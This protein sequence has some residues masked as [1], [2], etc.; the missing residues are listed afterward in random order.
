MEVLAIIPARSGSKSVKNKNIRSFNGKPLLA[1]SIQ[2]ALDSERVTRVIVS[3]DSEEYAL[4]AK[5][6]GAEVPFLRPEEISQDKSLDIET[7][8][9]ALTWLKENESYVPDVVVHLRPTYPIRNPK[10]IDT[11]VDLLLSDACADAVRCITPAKE[12]P[13]KMWRCGDDGTLTSLLND[14]PEAYNMPRQELPMVYY[15]NACIDVI[16]ASTITV[17]RSMTGD[18]ILG[19][20]MDHFFDIDTEEDFIRAEQYEKIKDGKH[21]FV[22]DIDG[23]ITIPQGNLDYNQAI[24]NKQTVALINELYNLGNEIV[25]FTARGY[26]TGIN[27]EELTQK[28]MHDWGVKY[29][30]LMFGKPDADY[31]V[32]DKLVDLQWLLNIYS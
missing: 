27:W 7:F 1:H 30:K 12:I 6:Y 28:Q 3:T 8:T 21:K 22:F 19:Y 5:E 32:D 4:I 15:Q 31:Y 25:L 20:K 16:R 17:K 10:D 13:Y 2:H 29:N 26:K 11:M 24:P 9:H 18:K 14:I 23:V